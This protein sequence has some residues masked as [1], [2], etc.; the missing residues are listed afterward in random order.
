MLV[1]R[2]ISGDAE[3]TVA[4]MDSNAAREWL[5]ADS[6]RIVEKPGPMLSYADS[7]QLP[8]KQEGNTQSE[9]HQSNPVKR[10][11]LTSPA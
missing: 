10:Y 6:I 3:D 1:T 11:C 9:D 8:L 4:V 5:E 7:V 2:A